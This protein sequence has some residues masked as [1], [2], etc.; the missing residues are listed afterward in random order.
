VM[1]S[2]SVL[3][4]WRLTARTDS[5]SVWPYQVVR[6]AV[7]DGRL[8]R[9]P[10]TLPKASG[11]VGVTTRAGATPS[12][13]TVALIAGLRTIAARIVDETNDTNGSDLA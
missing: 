4:N 12:P 6:Q 2:V 7:L 5:I 1:E 10:I 11:T 13:V 9:L 8:M 3:T